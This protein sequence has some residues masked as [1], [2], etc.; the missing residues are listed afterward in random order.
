MITPG[1]G[2]PGP[3]GG[4]GGWRSGGVQTP[5]CGGAQWAPL[6]GGDSQEGHYYTWARQQVLPVLPILLLLLFPRTTAGW[7]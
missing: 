3:A 5:D 2:V 4:G 6:S 7:C 1:G